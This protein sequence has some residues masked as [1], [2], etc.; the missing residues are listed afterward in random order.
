MATS[1]FQIQYRREIIAGF[2]KTQSI[3]RDCVTTEFVNKGGSAVF[4]VSDTAGENAVTRGLNGLIPAD[5]LNLTQNT[6]SLAE[7]HK[8]VV[9]N[10]FN[11]FAS[12]GDLKK[13]MQEKTMAAINRKID[14]DIISI[15]NTGTLNTGAAVTGSV[16]LIG[17]GRVILGNNKVPN[18]GNLT[19]LATPALI[20]YLTRTPEFSSAEYVSSRPYED[21][22]PAFGDQRMMFKWRGMNVIED[23]T[24]PGVGTAA[25]KCF[26]FHKNAVGQAIDKA[27]MSVELGYDGEDH[28]SWARTSVYTGSVKLQNSGIVVINH[29][30]SAL[31]SA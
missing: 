12:Q 25:E 3:L 10:D 23:P 2:D 26:L 14:D 27:A 7:W 15:L 17:K 28:Y 16:A 21:G 30:G 1:A 29:D 6:A 13:P 9:V 8:K 4:L 11:I 19:L 20:D 18:D 22:E 24:L 5:P 31:V